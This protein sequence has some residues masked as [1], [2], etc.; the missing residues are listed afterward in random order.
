MAAAGVRVVPGFHGAEQSEG[1]LAAEAA[2]LGFPLLVKAVAGGGG[3]G[4]KL[5]ATEAEFLPA[6][7]AARREAEAAFGDGRVLLERFVAAPRHVEVQVRG[8]AGGWVGGWVVCGWFVSYDLA[9]C[10]PFRF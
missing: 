8:R 2:T 5:A 1:R 10:C 6:L 9:R 4:L 3:K 7:R